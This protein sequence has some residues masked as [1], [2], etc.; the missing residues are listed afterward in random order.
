[1]ATKGKT[2]KKAETKDKPEVNAA[3]SEPNTESGAQKKAAG[4][5]EVKV[6]L[7]NGKVRGLNKTEMSLIES[8]NSGTEISYTKVGDEVFYEVKKG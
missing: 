4:W 6:H 3:K 2:P 5:D 1:M 8:I 7:P